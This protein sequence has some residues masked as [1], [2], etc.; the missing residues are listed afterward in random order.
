MIKRDEELL[1]VG[2]ESQVSKTARPGAHAA[3]L[4]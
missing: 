1:G 3:A 2:E 4:L